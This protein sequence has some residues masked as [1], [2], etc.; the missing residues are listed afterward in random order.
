[1]ILFNQDSKV[2]L[3]NALRRE[4]LTLRL[5]ANGIPVTFAPATLT[6]VLLLPVLPSW[7]AVCLAVIAAPIEVA[8]IDSL[9]EDQRIPEQVRHALSVEGGLLRR[10]CVGC[11]VRCPCGRI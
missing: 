5:V 1:V 9:L 10:I 6:A 7:E 4:H 11:S 8:L 2:D 3:R